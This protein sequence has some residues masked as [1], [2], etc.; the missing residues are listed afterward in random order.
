M[1]YV[2]ANTKTKK[3]ELLK[4]L[5]TSVVKDKEPELPTMLSDF[6]LTSTVKDKEPELPT[7]LSVFL[8]TSTGKDKDPE[9]PIECFLS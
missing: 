5:L 2:L 1:Y 6:S 7:T 4:I 8:L 3:S 9:L